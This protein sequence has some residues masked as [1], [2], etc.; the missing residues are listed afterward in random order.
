MRILLLFLVVTSQSIAQIGMGEWRLHVPNNKAVSTQTDGNLIYAAYENGLIE[1]DPEYNEASIWDYVNGLSDIELSAL[2][3]D[4]SSKSLWIGYESGNIDQLK[5]NRITNQP[6]IVLS[7]IIGTKRVNKINAQN[8]RIYVAT[9]FG[10][11]VLN[12]DNLEVRDTY[13]PT[14]GSAPINDIAFK[15]DTIF[16]IS[17]SSMY[18]GL[19]SNIALADPNQWNVDSRVP[20]LTNTDYLYKDLELVN[21]QLYLQKNYIEPAGDSVFYITNTGLNL[22]TNTGFDIE[23]NSLSET[24]DKITVNAKGFMLIY[25]DDHE[26]Y[27]TPTGYTFGEEMQ[28]NYSIERFNEIWIADNQFGLVRHDPNGASE[29][30]TVKG[31]P[32]SEFFGMDWRDGTLAVAPGG[33]Q[34]KF[35]TFTPAGAYFFKDEEWT[36][37]TRY[38]QNLWGGKTIWDNICISINPKNKNQY[39]TGTYS[40]YPLSIGLIDGQITDT[41]TVH[42]SPL[43]ESSEGNSYYLISDVE[44]D[45]DG[46]LWV[47]NGFSTNPL[48]V[49]TKDGAWQEFSFGTNSINKQTKNMVVDG[50]N[51]VWFVVAST[52]LYG[53]NPGSDLVDP[54]DDASVFL[55]IGEYTGAL[56]SNDVTALALDFDNELWIGT[57][58]GFA[59][60]YNSANAFEAGP[61][62]YNAQR[63]KLEFEGNVEYL[64]G[65]TYITDIEVDGGNRKWMGT[66]NSGIILL[67]AD[68]SEIIRHFTSENSPLISNNIMDMEIDHNTG[69]VFIITDKGLISYR[70]DASDGDSDYS[71]VTVFPNPAR[72]EFDGPIT[73]QGIKYDSDIKVTDIAGNLIYKTTSNGGTA[74]WNGRTVTGEKVS[75]GVYL[76]WTATNEGKG[77]FVGKVLVVN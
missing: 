49:Y 54:S 52:G 44:Y 14:N 6:A 69:E 5:D 57:D 24:Y 61:G 50:D 40:Q 73:I 76:F 10:I 60:L 13:Y 3:Y 62:E 77:R 42:N 56:P 75:T 66:A 38:N 1:F 9:G 63:I 47:L 46:N 74:T 17:N 37:K 8:G 68:G 41:F 30:I 70:S 58:N 12:P 29:R 55:N 35:P 48:K 11:V 4:P 16:A 59:I 28:V 43:Q 2:Y 31:P 51:N 27:L 25:S 72:P 67:S 19:T 20:L 18:W 39:A 26:Y 23:I 36:E 21:D 65:N 71:D 15:G 64:L 53:Y 32:R 33:I 22:L 7:T 34:S 45:Q